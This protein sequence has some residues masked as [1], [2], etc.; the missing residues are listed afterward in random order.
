MTLEKAFEISTLV[1]IMIRILVINFVASIAG[2]SA[3]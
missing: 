1:I 3:Y 2:P